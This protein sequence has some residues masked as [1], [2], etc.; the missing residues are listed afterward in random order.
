[1]GFN[2]AERSL[3][4][5]SQIIRQ[6]DLLVEWF[7]LQHFKLLTVRLNFLSLSSSASQ[8]SLLNCLVARLPTNWLG[9]R[10]GC[11]SNTPELLT[12]LG[13]YL[14]HFPSTLLRA[15]VSGI[16]TGRLD[17]SDLINFFCNFILVRP[18]KTTSSPTMTTWFNGVSA[19]SVYRILDQVGKNEDCSH[20]TI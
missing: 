1:M 14:V 18:T 6:R 20:G 15:S 9:H 16:P 17:Q 10:V 5:I 7:R 19:W 2:F 11:P 8:L 13:A 4:S 3:N 12:R